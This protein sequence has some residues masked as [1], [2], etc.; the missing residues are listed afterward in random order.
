MAIIIAAAGI[1][2][3]SLSSAASLACKRGS[4]ADVKSYNDAMTLL[5]AGK[6]LTVEQE[7]WILRELERGVTNQCSK[8][9]IALSEVKS[10]AFERAYAP[11][12]PI[13]P[14]LDAQIYPLLLEASRIGEGDYEL[15]S[16]LLF[17]KSKF[18][19][20]PRGLSLLERAAKRGDERAIEF[21]AEAYGKGNW[22][23][24]RDSA[25]A[26]HW[27]EKIGK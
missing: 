8:A 13:D 1:G 3:V 26:Q 2:C 15:G 5:T 19:D 14:R 16:F 4:Q 21:L 22:G 23:L 17:K 25:K 18:F 7:Q 10:M 6:R 27:Q 9:A 12:A 24:P 20:L 11:D